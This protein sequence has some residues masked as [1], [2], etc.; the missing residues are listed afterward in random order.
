M[1]GYLPLLI[2]ISLLIDFRHNF[3]ARA[4]RSSR[5]YAGTL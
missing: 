2:S 1:R 3:S 5:G 4:C